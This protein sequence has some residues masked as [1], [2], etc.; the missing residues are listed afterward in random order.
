MTQLTFLF[1]VA[2][3]DDDIQII[4]DSS[5]NGVNET[6][7]APN[8]GI[9]NVQT[10]TWYIVA[11]THMGDFDIG[12]CWH[13]FLLHPWDQAMFGVKLPEELAKE[14]GRAWF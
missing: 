7:W 14:W 12:E 6:L 3:G 5:G 4:W 2:K 8:F 9:P 11:K 1:V 13:N 10:M